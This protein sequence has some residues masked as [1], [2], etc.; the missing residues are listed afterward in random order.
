MKSFREFIEESKDKT[1]IGITGKPVPDKKMS[2]AKR[3]EFEKK[4]R[5]NLKKTPGQSGDSP[6]IQALRDKAKKEGNF[7]EDIENG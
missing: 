1:K 3:Y 2:P 5:E 6:L 7:A 4:R